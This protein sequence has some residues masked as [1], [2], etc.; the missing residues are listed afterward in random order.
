MTTHRAKATTSKKAAHKGTA[1]Q[2]RR[3]SMSDPQEWAKK[4]IEA[5]ADGRSAERAEN[6]FLRAEVERLRA[7]NERLRAELYA[8]SKPHLDELAR[9]TAA[10]GLKE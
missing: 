6:R 7:D 2:R 8:R 4:W 3:D 5:Q 10:L 9:E 1:S